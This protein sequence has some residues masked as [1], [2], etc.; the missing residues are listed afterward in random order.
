MHRRNRYNTPPNYKL[1]AKVSPELSLLLNDGQLDFTSNEAVR[2]LNRALLKADFNLNVDI[3]SVNL[4]PTIAN[5]LDYLHLVEDLLDAASIS[6]RTRPVSIYDMLHDNWT[7]IATEIDPASYESAHGN[8]ATNG[9]NDQIQ[10]FQIESQNAPLLSFVKETGCTAIVCNP[11]FY[12]S[13]K[14]ICSRKAEK[15][16]KSRTN[17]EYSASESIYPGGEVA[18]ISRI[19]EESEQL[20]EKITWYT[21]LVGLK[22]SIRPLQEKL[23]L[24]VPR[25]TIKVMPSQIGK[26]K[27]WVLAWTFHNLRKRSHASVIELILPENITDPKEWLDQQFA[28]LGITALPDGHYQT[29]YCSWNRKFQRLQSKNVLPPEMPFQSKDTLSLEM[30]FQALV[31][32]RTVEFRESEI[33]NREDLNSLVNHLRR[34]I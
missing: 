34:K 2:V 14:D 30:Q 25:P 6:Y 4:C 11:P 21:S 12:S 20:R 24:L 26:T 33:H 5:R 7:F 17:L 9:L 19:I 27:R 31:M 22:D 16:S 28:K 3:P 13:T 32:G 15:R 29:S 8:V 18:F 10:L 1:V 23:E